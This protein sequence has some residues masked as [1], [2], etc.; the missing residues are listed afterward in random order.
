MRPEDRELVARDPEL[1]GLALLL[2][3]DAFTALLQERVPGAAIRRARGTYVRYKPGT[4]CLVAFEAETGT[5]TH[6]LYA[7]AERPAET[8]KLHKRAADGPLAGGSLIAGDHGVAVLA[9]P[10]DRRIPALPSLAT[11]N[12]PVSILAYKPERR[13]VA[14]AGEMVVKAYSRDRFAAARVA[15]KALRPAGDLS[16]QR[17]VRASERR[18]TLTFAWV[19][20]R[21]LDALVGAGDVSGR[22]AE[23]AAALS[24]LHAC[25]P[26]RPLPRRSPAAEAEA[27]LAAAGAT[28]VAGPAVA[29][30]AHRLAESLV[31]RSEAPAERARPLHGDFSVDQVVLGRAGA[32][33]LDLDAA[34]IGDPAED[35]GSALADLEL[36]VL[37]ERLAAGA[38]GAFAED[39][40]AACPAHRERAAHFAAVGLLRRAAE[41]F[42]RR[43]PGWDAHVAAAVERAAV[44][45]ARPARARPR[46]T[47]TADV[48]AALERLP[49]PEAGEAV[50]RRAWP[51]PGRRLLLE[52]AGA[53][54]IVGA[55]WHA[56]RERLAARGSSD[57]RV[58]R[59]V[60][61][62]PV[63]VHRRGTDE[64]LPGLGAV[65]ARPHAELLAHRPTKRAV[66][67]LRRPAPAFV[68]VVR[69][70]RAQ[71]V[72][73]AIGRAAELAGGAFRVPAVL[74][75]DVAAGTVTCAPVPGRPLSGLL[76]SPLGEAAAR[77]LGAAVRVL[78]D[79][80]VP[81]GVAVH[82]A[83]DEAAL[84]RRFA[85]E[86]APYAPAVAAAAAGV[87]E[88][89]AGRL[90]AFPPAP[91]VPLHRDLH[92]KQVLVDDR[93][94]VGLI[95][96]DT[97]AA[98]DPAL[99]V[100][101]LL[102]HL[103]L[104]AL[105]YRCTPM[106]AGALRAAFLAGYGGD[107][108]VEERAGAYA[109]ATRV[110]LAC[111]YALRPSWPWLGES[112]LAATRSRA[113]IRA[114]SSANENGLIR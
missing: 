5:G 96:F 51:R 110:R 26:T 23:A 25:T 49:V 106:V 92:D 47:R 100:G 82:D 113:S 77:A 32:V 21:P 20:G 107:D 91:L 42:R 74:E 52:Y 55:Q 8:A 22:A 17:L 6:R 86:V 1:P 24:A 3:D 103:E 30:A 15:A 111:V 7:R 94:A 58:A 87:A 63:L 4:N 102:A 11:G 45:A 57:A 61:G 43:R 46:R 79:A 88:A 53:G 40:M 80:P 112:L 75:V 28:A 35:F 69:P 104:R 65:L 90:G 108:E 36:R 19:E 59:T 109:A 39:L 73:E 9:F 72:A 99:D 66:V 97:L 78:H 29:R 48:L 76:T 68:K 60:A 44:L 62:M 67:A 56:D 98:G 105:Q 114:S 38:A 85:A 64:R 14:R 33:L 101:N 2:D 12:G 50:L 81:P 84:V 27:L 71:A 89:V 13:L 18:A 93:G 83:A 10:N 31:R 95:D 34:A 54:G 16:L 37:E 70:E 41:P